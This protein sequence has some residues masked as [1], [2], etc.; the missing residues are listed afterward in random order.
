MPALLLN[1]YV[2]Y[3]IGAALIAGALLWYH[4]HVWKS[5][6]DAR[7]KDFTAF[8][9]QV[10]ATGKA[11]A[12]EAVWE[13]HNNEMRKETA[14]AEHAQ[15]KA[16]L[17]TALNSLRVQ[18]DNRSFTVPAAPAGTGRPD[19]ACFDRADYQRAN[20]ETLVRLRSGARSLADEGTAG[21][22]DLNTA[23]KWA[24]SK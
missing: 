10:D 15:T 7:D 9:A 5:G 17:A 6:W 19:L 13:Q 2:L 4:H 16:T 14:D 3:A 12:A 18:S 11:A 22:V 1:K 8:K 24:Q 20:G 21:T 23:K